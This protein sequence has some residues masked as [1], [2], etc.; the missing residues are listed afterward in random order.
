MKSRCIFSL[1]FYIIYKILET[2]QASIQ[3]NT[4][5][6]LTPHHLEP[7]MQQEINDIGKFFTTSEKFGSSAN[8]LPVG[9]N[10]HLIKVILCNRLATSFQ[11]DF[12]ISA[13]EGFSHDTSVSTSGWSTALQ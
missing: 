5:D 3:E 6:N 4:D 13:D 7:M 9:Q 1:R 2:S 8:K 11:R 12:F 10:Y